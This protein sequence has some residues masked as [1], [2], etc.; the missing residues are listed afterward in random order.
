MAA[1][2]AQGRQRRDHHDH[3]KATECRPRSSADIVV[4]PAQAGL[5]GEVTQQ[6]HEADRTDAFYFD[7]ITQLRLGSAGH[8]ATQHGPCHPAARGLG[9]DLLLLLQ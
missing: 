7:S 3:E 2:A 1:Q 6:L 4:S 8:L 9:S 5:D